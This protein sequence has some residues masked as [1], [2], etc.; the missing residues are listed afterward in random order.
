MVE[1]KTLGQIAYET[2]YGNAQMR[3]ADEILDWPGTHEMWKQIWQ[4]TAQAVRL[5]TIEECAEVSDGYAR[6]AWDAQPSAQAAAVAA[7]HISSGIRTLK[8]KTNDQG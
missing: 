3:G 2:Y 6:R 5:R 8:D 7:E 4:A 1:A